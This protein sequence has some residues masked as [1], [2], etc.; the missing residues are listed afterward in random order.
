MKKS[1]FGKVAVLALGMT[2]P[3]FAADL[4]A[5]TY[6]KAPAHVEAPIYNWTG[7]YIGGHI[8][9]A[10]ENNNN[11]V[12]GV[13]GSNNGRF[14]GGG[15]IGADYQFAP[16]W[17]L[18]IEAQ[19]SWTGNNSTTVTFA[20]PPITTFSRTSGDLGSVTGRLGYTWGPSL[21][22]V[23]GGYA[24]QNS[25]YTVASAG[26][27]AAFSLNGN[28]RDGYTV[29]AGFEYMFAPS[30]SAKVEYQYYNFGGTNFVTGPAPLVAAGTFRDDVQT[31]KLGVNYH[32]NWGGPIAAR[33]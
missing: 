29:G 17:V 32:F 30:W 26:V 25:S 15:Q 18:G 4:P 27:P 20:G 11:F 3:A 21:L 13:G 9:G 23:K 5:R 2:A 33:Y 22:Y 1:L 16:N 19:Y 14:M 10:F 24:Y 8:G 12:G 7:F 6:S 28:Q 31:V